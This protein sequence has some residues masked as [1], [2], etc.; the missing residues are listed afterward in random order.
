MIVGDDLADWLRGCKA[1]SRDRRATMEDVAGRYRRH[2]LPGAPEARGWAPRSKRARRRCWRWPRLHRGRCARSASLLEAASPRPPP[3]PFAGR[4]CGVAQRGAGRAGAVRATRAQHQARRDERRRPR[5]QARPAEGP[6]L[7]LLHRPAQPVPVREGRRRDPVPLG[8]A[9]DRTGFHRRFERPLP[10]R[11]DAAGSPTARSSSSTAGARASSSS[12]AELRHRLSL[13][14]RRRSRRAR[15]ASNMIRTTLELRGASST[16]EAGSRIQM[17]LALL[18]M[19]DRRDAAPLFARDAAARLISMRAGRRCASSSR[20]IPAR[21]AAPAA[22][23]AADPHAEV[24][25]AA[26]QTLAAFFP[27]EREIGRR[28]LCPC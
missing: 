8:G 28:R 21:P 25:A 10:V 1:A 13:R 20:W 6:R 27:D 26:A 15:S 7:D 14:R 4:H 12:S 5:R 3:T 19:L 11:R 2:A 22:M 23:A 17:M 16:D 24:R 9:H 18:R